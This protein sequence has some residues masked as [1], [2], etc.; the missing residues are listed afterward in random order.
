M[1]KSILEFFRELPDVRRQAG[2]RHEQGFILL[3]VLMSTMCGYHGYRPIGDFISR[4]REDLVS[5]FRPKKGRLP[6]FDTV[7]R[8]VQ[9]LNFGELAGA[10]YGW[11]RQHMSLS[12]NEWVHI[13]G[14]AIK[15]TVSG[16]SDERQ[17]F[18]SLVTLYASRSGLSIGCGLVDN[19]KESE[20]P[21]VR[22]LIST[23]GLS[24]VS[25]TMDALHCQKKRPRQS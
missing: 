23:L 3:L 15:G 17:R 19:S 7:R 10:F 1:N 13:D 4:N 14:K 9:C 20:I 21:E 12:A 22:Q 24:G 18:I 8:V 11:S 5:H 6:S 2:M 25:F 16:Y